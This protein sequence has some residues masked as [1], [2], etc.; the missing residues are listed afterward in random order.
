MDTVSGLHVNTVGLG[1]GSMSHVRPPRRA[2]KPKAAARHHSDVKTLIYVLFHKF[3][4]IF[5][6][7]SHHI[8]SHFIISS[9][10]LKLFSSRHFFLTI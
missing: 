10:L 7:F 3:Q 4:L 8:L 2:L 5:L 1:D 6:V 9:F